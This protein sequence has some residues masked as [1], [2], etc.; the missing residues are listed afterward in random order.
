ML[1]RLVRR[2][3]PCGPTTGLTSSPSSLAIPRPFHISPL[4]RS[5]NAIIVPHI[6]AAPLQFMGNSPL[7]Y[8]PLSRLTNAIIVTPY[9]HS[10]SSVH[11]ELAPE[12]PLPNLIRLLPTL[13]PTLL[14]LLNFHLRL[15]HL[16]RRLTHITNTRRSLMHRPTLLCS[17]NRHGSRLRI[18]A[19]IRNRICSETRTVV[20]RTSS[21]RFGASSEG[22]RPVV[23]LALHGTCEVRWVSRSTTRYASA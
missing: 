10:T 6:I 19:R 9:H 8:L 3:P 11:E 21:G 18:R 12:N 15:R 7:S 17:R 20:C 13:Q 16:L 2:A 4:R 5:T 23:A 1:K 14:L 22:L